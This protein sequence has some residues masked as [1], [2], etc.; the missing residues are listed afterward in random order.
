MP[1]LVVEYSDNVARHHDIDELLAVVHD[2]ALATG[3]PPLAGLRTRG[4]SRAHYRIAT[5]DP[6]FAFI[7]IVARIGPGRSPDDKTA[8]LNAVLDAAEAEVDRAGGPL[9]VSW[10]IEIQEI[11]A[12]FRINRNHIR[13]RLEEGAR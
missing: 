10:S 2:A 12:G 8:F 7:A 9:V 5:G 11:D 13:S 3:L 4:V 6:D 1:H